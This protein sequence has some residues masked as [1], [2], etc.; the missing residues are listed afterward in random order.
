LSL[1]I[2][3]DHLVGMEMGKTLEQRSGTNQLKW[4]GWERAGRWKETEG[5][6]ALSPFRV[7]L[8]YRPYPPTA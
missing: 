4:S 5:R 1:D 3:V 6:L 2:S 7:K 8:R